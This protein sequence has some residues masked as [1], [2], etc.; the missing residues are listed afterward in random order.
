MTNGFR[1]LAPRNLMPKPSPGAQLAAMRKT[2]GGPPRKLEE[3]PKC[4]QM[5]TARERRRKCPAH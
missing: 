3:C 4:K 2:H 1:L 5:L